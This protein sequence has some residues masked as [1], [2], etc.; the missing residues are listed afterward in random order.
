[1]FCNK[2]GCVAL[3][4]LCKDFT[5]LIG[6]A[7][8]KYKGSVEKRAKTQHKIFKPLSAA[9]CVVGYAFMT[10][11]SYLHLAIHAQIIPIEEEK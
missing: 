7:D 2:L 10:P 1:M 8:P 11:S 6:L 9:G 5:F 4:K 3:C